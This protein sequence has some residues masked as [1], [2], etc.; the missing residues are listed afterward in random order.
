MTAATMPSRWPAW[1]AP[2]PRPRH[3]MTAAQEAT[4]RALV[5]LL[6]VP[7]GEARR[8]ALLHPTFTQAT[9]DVL[10]RRYGGTAEEL[11]DGVARRLPAEGVARR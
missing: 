9:A 10:A 1:L 2:R 3:A 4:E 5:R 7:D 8:L 6:D 11:L